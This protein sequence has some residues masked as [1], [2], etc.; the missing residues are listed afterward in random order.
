MHILLG[1]LAVAG[2]IIFWILRARAAA[3][4]TRELV[5]VA[6]DV[7]AAVRR[8]GLRRSAGRHPAETVEDTRLAAAGVLASIARLE[9]DPS[10][11][12]IKRI[13]VECQATFRC[14]VDEAKDIAAFGRWLASQSQCPDDALRRCLRRLVHLSTPE[15]R[16]QL[17]S[18]MDGMMTRIVSAD[19]GEVSN[20][21]RH[22]I[23][24]ATRTLRGE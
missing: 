23:A 15:D 2:A 1:V 19:A 24:Q 17:A 6:D 13:A 12:T 11:E 21:A 8:F 18:D 20:V 14:G 9:G 10:A 4:A 22:A 16:A 3:D 5:D 7:R